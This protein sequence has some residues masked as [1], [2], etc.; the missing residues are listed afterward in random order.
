MKRLVFL[1]SGNP[2][3][4][5]QRY[6]VLPY[7][8][9]F[10]QEGMWAGWARLPRSLPHRLAAI[11][12]LRRADVVV[13]HRLLPPGWELRLIRRFARQLVY[14]VD[15]ALPEVRDAGPSRRARLRRRF[16]RITRDADQVIV[17]NRTLASSVAASAG[18]VLILPTPVDTERFRP[19]PHTNPAPV[20]VWS[21]TSGN[22]HYLDEVLPALRRLAGMRE[23]RLRVSCDRPLAV[24]GLPI[25]NRR[26]T[27]E[28]DAADMATA[29]INLMPLPD[30]PW[31]RGKCGYKLLLGMSCG[32]PS[33]ASP[34]GMN[35][36]IVIHGRDGFLAASHR[37]WVASLA[38]LLSD[39]KLRRDV[40]LAARARVQEAYSLDRCYPCLRDFLFEAAGRAV[41]Q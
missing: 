13:I 28:C 1:T 41:S 2:L 7:V 11:V 39:E 35:G 32:L 19:V 17:G 23:F 37:E 29:D 30:N 34:V 14:D 22:L 20:L 16:R 10:R 5:S 33:V 15:D 4:P 21:G 12:R 25:E 18:R 38:G 36:E 24:D 9:R 27:P 3:C 6:R 26:W 40:G 31:T 8:E